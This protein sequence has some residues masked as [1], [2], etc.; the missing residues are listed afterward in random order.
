MRN[1]ALL[2]LLLARVSTLSAD[3]LSTSTAPWRHRLYALSTAS[4]Q[5]LESISQMTLAQKAARLLIVG[6]DGTALSSH[7]TVIEAVAR[8]GV[9]GVI[10]FEKNIAPSSDSVS[11]REQLRRF[12]TEIKSHA[13]YPLFM[14]IDQEGG[15]VNRLK[16]KYGFAPQPSQ[17]SVGSSG[18]ID[19][20]RNAAS[21]IASSL[22]D[23]GLNLNFS[24]CVDLNTNPSCPIIGAVNRSFSADER[25]V[26]RLAQIYCEE[27]RKWGVYNAIKHFPGH[28]S[29]VD[30]SHLGFTDVTNTWQLN[31][32]TPYFD[33][34]RA[35]ACDMV[36][37]SHLYNRNIDSL[38]P[39]SLSQKSIEGL[40]RGVIGW[41]GVVV[42]DDMQMRSIVDHYGFE[43]SIILGIN[44]G[45][46]LFII[47]GNLRR[48][49][50][51]IT[52][53][54]I[55]AV[56]DGVERGEISEWQIDKSLQRVLTLIN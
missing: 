30:D 6:V 18:D 9:S 39:A 23:V 10:F 28:G 26:S 21:T 43:Q 42:S 45:I 55:E 37:V 49:S 27:F 40:L 44:A 31:E 48:E 38:H 46:D 3:S 52:E 32:L 36:L 56:V 34:V 54:F 4:S 53:R 19:M 41:Q 17:A 50:F 5:T 15:A 47:S 35:D 20:A 12:V 51:N 2:L 33:L 13:T 25:E 11:G 29:S 8:R 16:P 24:P 1:I 22:A 14:A 7:N